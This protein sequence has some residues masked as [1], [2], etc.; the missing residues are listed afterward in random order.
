MIIYLL[1]SASCLALLLFFYHFILEKEKMHTFNRF[2]LLTG[3]IISFL[4]P[5]TTIT[6]QAKDAI[7]TNGE[8]IFMGNTTSTTGYETFNYSQLLMVTYLIIATLFLV[9]FVVNLVRI[10][11]KIR[12]NETIKY[13]KAVLVLV[14]DE[15]LPHTFWN[16]IF[17][18]KKDYK[19]EKIEEELFTHELTHATQKHTLDVLLIELLQIIFWINPL[20]IFL[21]KAIQLNH[22]FLADEKVNHQH[23]NTFQYQHILVNKAAWNNEYYLAS[24][25]NYSL[26]KKRLKMMTKQSSPTNMLLKKLAVIPLLTAFIFLFAKR[27]EAQEKQISVSKHEITTESNFPTTGFKIIKGEKYFYVLKDKNYKYYNREGKLTDQNGKVISSQQVNAGDIIEGQ[28]I[29]KVYDNGE[30]VSEFKD[31][32]P[33]AYK[34]LQKSTTDKIIPPPPPT[35]KPSVSKTNKKETTFTIDGKTVTKEEIN[36]VDSENIESVNVMKQKDG[37]STISIKKKKEPIY[38][39]DGKIISKKEMEQ[40]KPTTIERVNVE[41]NKDGSGAV[42]IISK[43]N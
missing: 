7:E 15:I 19:Q 16:Y 20:F 18:N 24:N 39:L 9:R 42:Y 14:K 28:F 23:N 13:Q 6:I 1:K 34:N 29:T 17:I 11:Q 35:S 37:T 2:Y 25:L 12:K 10:I 3:I 33:D 41:K 38:Y 27:V 31:N 43:K 30:I 8:P 4:V 32:T 40:I 26:T 22:E 21:K 5:L 36:N